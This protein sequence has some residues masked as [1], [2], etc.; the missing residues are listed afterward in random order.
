M[1]SEPKRPIEEL[2]EASAKAR[3]AEFGTEAKMPNS[4]RAQLHAEIARRAR[5]PEPR[6]RRSWLA[7]FWPQISVVTALAA[8]IITGA[9]LWLRS[10]KQERRTAVAMNAPA[11]DAAAESRTPAQLLAKAEEA[12]QP[13]EAAESE[14]GAAVAKS[15]ADAATAAAPAVASAPAATEMMREEVPRAPAAAAR[16]FAQTRDAAQANLRQRFSQL[17]QGRESKLKQSTNIL[18]NFDVQQEGERIS[19]VDEDGSTYTGKLEP[20]VA[21]NEVRK[22]LP[23]KR[24]AAAPQQIGATLNQANE[25]KFR[26]EGFNNSLKKRV[27]FEGNYIAPTEAVQSKAETGSGDQAQAAAR[28]IGTAK[29]AGE[30]P[31][32]V[33]A[34]LVTH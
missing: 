25:F 21:Q 27:V 14:A 9:A 24:A 31:I 4:M 20:V 22:D 19:V 16:S 17:P 15:Y 10:Q 13:A 33:D 6:E 8:I 12:K 5:E 3:R 34:V 1:A 2:L 32:Q 11:A 28:V 18:N 7:M 23:Q 30:P 26:A 29:V